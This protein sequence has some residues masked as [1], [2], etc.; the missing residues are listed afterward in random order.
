MKHGN[1]QR[2]PKVTGN[3]VTRL[4]VALGSAGCSV[5]GLP[6]VL[7]PGQA[8]AT[9]A[10]EL[11][12]QLRRATGALKSAR[13]RLVPALTGCLST[14]T[15]QRRAGQKTELPLQLEDVSSGFDLKMRSAPT[16]IISEKYAR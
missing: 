8:A 16:I 10:T 13:M 12:A 7:L 9:A 3:L 6:R 14:V 15:W 2:S 5:V 4:R 11:I 1:K